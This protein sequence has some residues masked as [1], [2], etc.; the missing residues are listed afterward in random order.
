[1]IF[2]K[3]LTQFWIRSGFSDNS[4]RMFET[5]IQVIIDIYL[6]SLE[7]LRPTPENF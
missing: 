4:K 7:K 2:T 3:V 6:W 5:L 1:M